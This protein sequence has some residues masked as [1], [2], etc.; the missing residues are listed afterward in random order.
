MSHID[1]SGKYNHTEIIPSVVFFKPNVAKASN[2]WMGASGKSLYFW[3]RHYMCRKNAFCLTS[4][5]VFMDRKMCTQ[6]LDGLHP[7]KQ[8][9]CCYAV[10][11]WGLRIRQF[12]PLWMLCWKNM[13]TMI[14]L[15]AYQLGR[16]KHLAVGTNRVCLAAKEKQCG[17]VLI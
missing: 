16:N 8:Q 4:V 15:S 11:H 13:K 3:Q 10:V 5:Q 12:R 1:S 2:N 9:I 17:A 14:L 7:V 6:K